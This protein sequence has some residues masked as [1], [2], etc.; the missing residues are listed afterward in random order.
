MKGDAALSKD[1]GDESI[2][3]IHGCSGIS[4]RNK[5]AF[6]QHVVDTVR[7]KTVP[8]KVKFHL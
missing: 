3:D 1:V 6:L 7:D 5:D 8:Q 2:S 4:S